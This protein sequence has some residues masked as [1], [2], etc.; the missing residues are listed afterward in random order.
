MWRE[1][2]RGSSPFADSGPVFASLRGF[3]P[4]DH[5]SLRAVGME[6]R[7]PGEQRP[8]RELGACFRQEHPP[9]TRSK[10]GSQRPGGSVIRKASGRARDPVP[11]GTVAG[12]GEGLRAADP[13]C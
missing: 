4:L 3:G 6:G 13:A 11:R 2:V 8:D 1:E 12:P 9:M 5:P 7:S 10:L